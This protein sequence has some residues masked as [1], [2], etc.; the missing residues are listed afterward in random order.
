MP[1]PNSGGLFDRLGNLVE[2]LTTLDVRVTNALEGL[3]EMRTSV[4]GLDPVR[5]DA[6]LMMADLKQ[7]L[8]VWDRRLGDDLAE[9]KALA[10]EKLNGLDELKALAMEKLGSLEVNDVGDRFDRMERALLSV[11]RETKALNSVLQ[12]SVEALPNFMSKRVKQDARKKAVEQNEV[13][14]ADEDLGH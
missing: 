13:P 11:E 5:D 3:E 14:F 7:R 10:I 6:Q 9:L 8:D 2:L 4:T 1:D 12:G